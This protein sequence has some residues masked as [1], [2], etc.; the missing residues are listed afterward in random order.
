L[1]STQSCLMKMQH[2]YSHNQ[3]IRSG[4]AFTK[5]IVD[6][7]TLGLGGSFAEAIINCGLDNVIDFGNFE[8]VESVIKSNGCES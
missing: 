1:H 2:Q 8:H 5:A 4:I 7:F 3:R 6:I